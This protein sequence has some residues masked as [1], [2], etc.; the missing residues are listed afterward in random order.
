MSFGNKSG[1]E[2]DLKIDVVADRHRL[3]L[4]GLTAV[5]LACL[6]F[7]VMR[8]LVTLRTGMLTP[9][10][11]NAAGLVAAAVL[12]TWYRRKPD[13]RSS[14]AA[15]GAALIA[16][17]ALLLPIAYQM[18]ST[19]WWLS[20]VGFAMVLLGRRHEARVW[21]VLI[22][23]L[24]VA[25]VIAEPH[26]QLQGAHGEP[27]V[28][29]ALSKIV[30][31]LVLIGMALGFRQVAEQRASE[32]HDSRTE[33]SRL[34]DE[35]EARAL[36]G[37]GLAA[38]RLER[39]E[40]VNSVLRAVRNVNQLIVQEKDPQRLI[41][42]V[43][44]AL[45]EARG[46]R[47]AWIA[48]ARE[49]G[50]AWAVSSSGDTAA[51][52]P[53]AAGMK[54]GIWPPCRERVVASD[55][56][57]AVLQADADCGSCPLRGSEHGE[58]PV[59]VTL[60]HQGK[61]QGLLGI[62]MPAGF[63]PDEGLL[64]EVANDISYALHGI[65]T[66]AERQQAE[67]NKT[68][69]LADLAERNRLLTESSGLAMAL[70]S[71]PIHEDARQLV[72]RRLRQIT[73]AAAAF[74]SD[75]DPDRR[76]LCTRGFDMQPGI[77]QKAVSLLGRRIEG[78]ES[79]VSEEAYAEMLAGTVGRRRT[80]TEVT[81]G[82][83][84]GPI[85]AAAQKL[86]GAER[87]IGFAHVAD[88]RLFGTS[89][90]AMKAG[91]PDPPDEW[92]LATAHMIAVTLR[93]QLAEAALQRSEAYNRA[94]VKS[95]PQKLFMKDRDSVY[96]AAN[97]AYAEDIGR[98]PD[99][100]VGRD[101]FALYPADLAE[102][103]RSD[104]RAVMESGEVK[105]LEG[106]HLAQ[107]RETWVQALKAPV[108]DDGGNI[109]GILGLFEDITERHWAEKALKE[110][111]EKFRRVFNEVHDGILVADQAKKGFILANESICNM[112][113]YSEQEL[114]R[115]GVDDIHPEQD[116]ADVLDRFE[117]QIR[118]TAPIAPSLPVKRKDGTVFRADVSA[119]P[120]TL[121]GR[122]CLVG[123][124]R[125]VTER[126][127]LQAS[128]AQSDRL[129][130]MGMLA[131]GVAHEINNPLSYVLYNL[132]SLSQEIPRH[133]RKLTAAHTA[134][135]GQLGEDSVQR[136]LGAGGDALSR[137][138]WMDVEERLEDALGGT[139]K[140]KG[141]ARGLGAFSR[142]EEDQM[143]PVSLVE[144]VEAAVNMASNEIRY[145]ARVIKDYGKVPMVLASEGRLSQVFL[146]LLINATHAI[147]EGDIEGN[148]IRVRTW[149]EKD[150]VLV[151][152]RDTGCGIPPENLGRLFDPFFTT[153]EIGV[154]SGLGLSIS[155]NI[156]ES[157]GGTLTVGSEVGKGT[158]FTVRLPVQPRK[159]DLAARAPQATEESTVRGRILIVEDEAPIRSAMVRML[160]GHETVEAA[161]GSE[162]RQLL[163]NDQ[164]F[165]LILC[166]MMMPDISGMELHQWLAEKH[167]RLA[168]DLIFI[169]GGAFTPRARE[170]LRKVDNLRL[171]KPFD[172]T[173][174][175]KIV[176]DRILISRGGG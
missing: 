32:L 176:N 138:V 29:T 163:E 117:E 62:A 107:G 65:E 162:A 161:N 20:L 3:V 34:K 73:G 175:K 2:A 58:A 45:T 108:R 41:D 48:L 156:V 64:C 153:K 33:L 35:F 115:L 30:F 168:K 50:P 135:V 159:D 124:F 17:L 91:Q 98:C 148:E 173:N 1:K 71:V 118:G 76:T 79:P 75:Y 120:I 106:R 145:R 144:V 167:P 27:F 99:D 44:E 13:T 87:F 43:C 5:G 155:K 37:E 160:T 165:D 157:Y 14:V 100:L 116:L 15:H 130:S 55:S 113:G 109:I 56:G 12:Y 9:W 28:E 174:F 83:I 103:Y 119:T 90:L 38:R 52:T 123:C 94:I 111:E 154:G 96:V 114:L 19:I 143:V 139:R 169:T 21:G 61:A 18:P 49:D 105:I 152:V 133:A 26:V 104:D 121:A 47:R 11:G 126:D 39:L 137:A 85:G 164:A 158:S 149:A 127:R 141:I 66:E 172:V 70:A 134:L 81:F 6:I 10:W 68:A 74:F 46:Y 54:R 78:F 151:E 88:G 171:E 25:S 77:V 102:K 125:D 31:V 7:A 128:L 92:L 23:L 51:F 147:T 80:L 140:I 150:C 72:A 84:S 63:E 60:R 69:A 40:Q 122:D 131:A 59:V 110:S 97:D 146:N 57:L 24:V 36:T 22:P 166:D 129:A 16:T 8:L 142:V 112:L 93:R 170:Y 53:V 86:L 95:I 89:M 82:A 67:Q 101:D 4:I 132:E 136:I 42:K